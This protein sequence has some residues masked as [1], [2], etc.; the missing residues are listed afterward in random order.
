MA[1]PSTEHKNAG[2]REA[3]RQQKSKKRNEMLSRVAAVFPVL[4]ATSIRAATVAELMEKSRLSEESGIKAGFTREAVVSP[5]HACAPTAGD[6]ARG[7]VLFHPPMASWF[8]GR[9]PAADEVTAAWQL[10]N[11]KGEIASTLL[12]A[13]ALAGRKGLVLRAKTPVADGTV[14]VECLPL[15]MAPLN[16][17]KKSSS[18]GVMGDAAGK[19]TFAEVGLWMAESGAVELPKGESRAWV[20]R[21]RVATNAAAGNLAI[22]VELAEGA[23]GPVLDTATLQL[24]VLPFVLADAWEHGHFFGAF[25]GGY[26]FPY[27]CTVEEFRQMHD[28]GIEAGHCFW[29]G[30][31]ATF[32]N[33]NGQLKVHLDEL[34]PWVANMQQ[35]GMR[36]PLVLTL[37]TSRADY[38]LDEITKTMRILTDGEF[39]DV[40]SNR[41]HYVSGIKQ[42]IDHAAEKHWPELVIMGPDEPTQSESKMRRHHRIVQMV[43]DASPKTRV[44]GVCMDRLKNARQVVDADILVCNGS[45]ESIVALGKEKHR[46]VW[47]YGSFT[48]ANG[49]GSVRC[50]YGLVPYAFGPTGEFFWSLGYNMGDP[51]NEFDGDRGDSVWNIAWPP[52]KKGDRLLVETVPFEGMRDGINDVRYA[53]TLEALLAKQ[54]GDRAAKVKADYETCRTT[55][56]RDAQSPAAVRGKLI[57]WILQLTGP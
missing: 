41:V 12:A 26:H 30:R 35:G 40:P 16:Q 24:K 23:D 53:M 57:A 32:E 36:G 9:P 8:T 38:F 46:T 54:T 55:E 14:A 17:A 21:V 52:V 56:M 29:S 2:I 44:Y 6:Q 33:V 10:A 49:Y 22:P 34:D 27:E 50:R 45:L 20:V 13:H 31:G 19:K 43:H 48:T 5:T 42:L 39:M 1:G 7:V 4:L 18:T 37:G 51:F 11:A 25:W 15:V 47:G 3:Q 28:H